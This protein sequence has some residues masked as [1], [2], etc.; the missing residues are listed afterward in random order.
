[1]FR[2][3]AVLEKPEMVQRAASAWAT[4]CKTCRCS[5]PWPGFSFRSFPSIERSTKDQQ[6]E[7]LVALLRGWPLEVSPSKNR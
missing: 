7:I 2:G 6:P 3:K 4:T 1:M 5:C